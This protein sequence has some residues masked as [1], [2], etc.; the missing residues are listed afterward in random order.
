MEVLDNLYKCFKHRIRDSS[1]YTSQV[2]R[3]LPKLLSRGEE[4][5]TL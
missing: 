2:E 3:S 1:H 4:R 5:S